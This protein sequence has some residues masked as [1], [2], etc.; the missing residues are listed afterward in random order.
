MRIAFDLDDTLIETT[1]RF[2]VGTEENPWWCRCFFREQLRQGTRELL[3]EFKQH[4]EVWIYT[5]SLRRVWVLK[6]WFLA[7]GIRLDGI[8]NQEIHDLTM[9]QHRSDVRFSKMPDIFGINLLIDDSHGVFSECQKQ[10]CRCIILVPYNLLWDERLKN[11]VLVKKF[12][13]LD[14]KRDS[15]NQ[16][17]LLHCLTERGSRQFLIGFEGIG[18]S[19]SGELEEL[20]LH[21][22]SRNQKF[23]EI[24]FAFYQGQEF[25]FPIDLS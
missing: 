6:L 13:I 22:L 21:T 20:V 14:L 16:S 7:L 1:V 12:I 3:K 18:A 24:L 8:I 23:G 17:V 19:F 5:N 11:R 9:R 15:E 25:E 4:H 10:K 2:T